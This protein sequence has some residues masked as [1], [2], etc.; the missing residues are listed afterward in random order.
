MDEL[1]ISISSS[2]CTSEELIASD[3]ERGRKVIRRVLNQLSD[4]R[5]ARHAE[6]RVD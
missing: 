6:T 3:P 2:F 4:G 1:D 5:V